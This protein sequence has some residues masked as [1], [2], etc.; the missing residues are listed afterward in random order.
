MHQTVIYMTVDDGS[1]GAVF[2]RFY[3]EFKLSGPDF[4]INP[5]RPLLQVSTVK[6]T[7]VY[8]TLIEPSDPF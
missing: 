6:K 2:S 3:D 1:V 4:A 5:P 8:L 7:S